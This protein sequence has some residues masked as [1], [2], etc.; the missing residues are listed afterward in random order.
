MTLGCWGKGKLSGIRLAFVYQVHLLDIH[1][2]HTQICSDQVF[3]VVFL[4]FHGYSSIDSK[5]SLGVVHDGE[6]V[7]WCSPGVDVVSFS[8]VVSHMLVNIIPEDIQVVV[9]VWTTL[10][11]MEAWERSGV[12]KVRLYELTVLEVNFSGSEHLLICI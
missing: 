6:V 12:E 11:M 9:S 2:R 5:S 10:F 1:G 4:G 8:E 7:V 3:V